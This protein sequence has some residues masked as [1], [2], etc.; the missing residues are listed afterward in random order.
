MNK[1]KSFRFFPI[2]IICL[3]FALLSL[4]LIGQQFYGTYSQDEALVSI[5]PPEAFKTELRDTSMRADCLV[6]TNSTDVNSVL[7][8]EDIHELFDQISIEADFIDLSQSEIPP[9][10]KYKKIIFVLTDYA[11]MGNTVYN[12]IDWV[13]DGGNLMIY[14]PPQENEYFRALASQLGIRELGWETYELTGITCKTSLLLGGQGKT[15][16]I[17]DSFNSSLTLEVTEDCTVHI[18]SADRKE[19]PVLW[20]KASGNGKIVFMNFGIT[21]KAYR[22]LYAAAYSLLDDSF[23][24][25]VI[26]GS[27][28][29]LDDFPSP[30]PSGTSEYIEEDYGLSVQDFYTNVWWPD[31]QELAEKYGLHYNGMVIE[32]YSDEIEAP[33]ETN[34]NAQRFQYFGSQLLRNGG[35]IGLHGYNHLPLCTESFSAGHEEGAYEDEYGYIYWE[36]VDDMKASVQELIS[37]TKSLYPGI[38]P[39]IYV[40]PSNVLSDEG[41]QMLG[42]EFP[43]IRGIA[44]SYFEDEFEYSQEFEVAED[45]IIELPRIISGCLITPYMEFAAFSELN[46]HYI[47]SHFQHPDD[48]LDV[49]R[50]AEEGWETMRNRF[51]EYLDWLY[52]SA[53]DI[54]NLTASEMAGAVQRYY[55][56]DVEQ[57]VTED[58]I[59]LNLTNFQDEAFLFLRINKRPPE[60]PETCIT[61][62][63]LQKMGGGLYLVTAASDHIVIE[64]GNA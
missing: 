41:R 54:R 57:E 58:E 50:G 46:L 14:F 2:I 36:S 55:Y 20:E 21:G 63:T 45:G 37:F 48:V 51:E 40:P 62:G 15:F 10:E 30:V 27:V 47:N 52:T 33:F 16:S 42:S 6:I 43:Q 53:P 26:N 29:Y 7:A 22:G 49:D 59:I 64:R 61:G 9:Y 60:D 32:D 38:E 39:C 8:E 17:Q 19:L 3:V 1:N 18:V 13:N 5:L 44:S 34:L 12:I 25:P 11:I 24:W 31:L 4:A 56:L 28:F 35:E 23:A